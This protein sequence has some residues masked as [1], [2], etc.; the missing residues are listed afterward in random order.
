M[1]K[2][3]H[4]PRCSK[5][6]QGVEILENSKKE[7]EIVKYLENVPTEKELTEIIKL[8]GITPIQLVRKTEKIWKEN[9]KGKELSDAE[10]INAMVENP[11]LIERPIVINNNK[12][13]IGRPTEAILDII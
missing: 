12:A 10:I 4:N 5:S 6:R 3:Y 11:K 1:I 2:I 8:L 13:V 7:F 9:Y